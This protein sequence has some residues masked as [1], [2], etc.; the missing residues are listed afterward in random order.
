MK[1][2]IKRFGKILISR[3]AG[4]EAFAVAKAYILPQEIEGEQEPKEI[5]LDFAG[6][7]V[8]SPSWADEL[9]TGLKTLFRSTKINFINTDNQSVQA[10]LESLSFVN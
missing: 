1:I 9:I 8:L 10:T 3:P 4:K 6:V 2:E 7:D 5:T